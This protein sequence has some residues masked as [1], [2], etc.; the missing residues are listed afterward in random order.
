MKTEQL[1]HI[2]YLMRLTRAIEDR[3]RTLFP[4]F[5][6]RLCLFPNISVA[7]QPAP[8]ASNKSIT[9]FLKLFRI[10]LHLCY[11]HRIS[12]GT[13]T[14]FYALSICSAGVMSI[15]RIDMLLSR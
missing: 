14:H 11:E 3:T 2:Y 8:A 5:L 15:R 1:H 10:F 13:R 4:V 9:Y 6:L 7:G 12:G